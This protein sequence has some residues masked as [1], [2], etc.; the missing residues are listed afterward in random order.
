MHS[1]RAGVAVTVLLVSSHAAV[2]QGPRPRKQYTIE[3]FMATTSLGGASF[4]P[5][6]SKL[7]LSSNET[8]IFNVYTVPV[9]GG[10][11]T[12]LTASAK[13]STYAVA[14]F[15]ADERVLFTRD[16]GGNELNH[17]YV[18]GVDGKEQDL[19][20]GEKLKAQFQGFTRAGDA[21]WVLTNERDARFFDLYR[22]DAQTYARTLHYKD[23]TGHF[24]G[25]VTDDGVWIALGKVQ[26]TADSDIYLYN[27]QKQD[28]K[29]LTPHEGQVSHG[30]A[31]FDPDGQAL[32]YL[33]NQGGEFARVKRYRL[34]TGAHEEVEKTDWDVASTTF[35]KNGRYR[36]TAINTE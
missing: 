31:G 16:Q 6:E 28:T 15:P 30:V 18:R 3:Q 29:H 36:V 11:P 8:G 32:Y 17:L 21:F 4:S 20:P 13:D 9:T 12:A 35:S 14:F 26:T 23:E 7:L 34:D 10:R 19:T 2:A 27:T 33:T 22:Y 25:D 24:F 1:V 5:D